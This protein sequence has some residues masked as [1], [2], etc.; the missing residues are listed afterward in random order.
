[1]LTRFA[2][3]VLPDPGGPSI[4]MLNAFN[5]KP[6]LGLIVAGQDLNK[7]CDDSPKATL[8]SVRTVADNL[9]CNWVIPFW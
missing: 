8:Y 2:S 1:M 6:F 3:I 4:R 7:G 5:P 9:G